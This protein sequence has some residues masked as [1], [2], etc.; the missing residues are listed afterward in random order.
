MHASWKGSDDVFGID[1][2]I[3]WIHAV[4]GSNIVGGNSGVDVG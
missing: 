4:Q 1:V 3:T 2:P